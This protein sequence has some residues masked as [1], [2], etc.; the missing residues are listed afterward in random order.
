MVVGLIANTRV[1]QMLRTWRAHRT[2]DLEV[3]Q[4][5]QAG[6]PVPPPLRVKQDVLRA[7]AEEYGLRILVETGTYFGD[8]V[9]ALKGLFGRIYTI[10]IS[11]A[12]CAYARKRF[13]GCPHVKVLEGD[14]GSVLGGVMP[15]VDEPCLFWLDGHFSGG[16]TARGERDT[17]I[18]QELEHIL[19]APDLGHVI[20]I[21]DARCFGTDPSYPTLGELVRFVKERRPDVEIV[22]ENDSIRILPVQPPS[23]RET[24]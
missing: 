22:T 12:L 8:T 18:N 19:G 13:R 10:E 4:W 7:Y 24:A 21:D 16:I 20:V 11:P 23:P 17:P 15:E 3:R 9:E 14:S 2:G 1:A 6:R 5:I